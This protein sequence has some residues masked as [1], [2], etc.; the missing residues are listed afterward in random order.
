M[1]G[2]KADIIF[3]LKKELLPLQGFQSLLRNRA[4]DA[5]LGPIKNAFPHASFPLG[6]IHEFLSTCPEDAAATGGF[7]GGILSSL[8]QNQGTALWISA[9]RSIFPPALQALGIAPHK[10]IFIDLKRENE[11]LWVMEEA[12]KCSGIAAVVGEMKEL[13]DRKSVV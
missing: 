13:S 1:T 2:T 11:I 7:V 6:A 9:N 8:M 10:M 12:L 3:Q 5:A 4:L